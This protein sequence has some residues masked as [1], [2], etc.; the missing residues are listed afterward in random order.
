M[1]TQDEETVEVTEKKEQIGQTSSAPNQVGA[2]M[3][4]LMA[5][6]GLTWNAQKQTFTAPVSLV[7]RGKPISE[8]VLEDRG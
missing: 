7:A 8:L 1:L 5:V 3:L 6:D 4:R 2:S